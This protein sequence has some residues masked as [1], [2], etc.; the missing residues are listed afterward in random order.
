MSRLK[1]DRLAL[2]TLLACDSEPINDTKS[3]FLHAFIAW[4]RLRTC[5][6]IGRRGAGVLP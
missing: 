1:K 3:L 5:P 4:H 2:T 6:L